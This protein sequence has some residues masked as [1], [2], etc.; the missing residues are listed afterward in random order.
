MAKS[1]VESDSMDSSIWS[2]S[3]RDSE[4]QR[5]MLL[6]S[7]LRHGEAKY[8]QCARKQKLPCPKSLLIGLKPG[9]VLAILLHR[10]QSCPSDR[11][12]GS[13]RHEDGRGGEEVEGSCASL[14]CSFRSIFKARK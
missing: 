1:A 10:F 6:L 12:E 5:A 9:I 8:H 3:F 14:S 7:N 2:R 13:G 11:V 4:R